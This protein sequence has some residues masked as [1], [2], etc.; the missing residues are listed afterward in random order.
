MYSIPRSSWVTMNGSAVVTMLFS[1]A[2]R[3]AAMETVMM[4]T[5]NHFAP[6]EAL[7]SRG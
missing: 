7:R 5:Q 3:R 1:S 2:L 4:M 6:V